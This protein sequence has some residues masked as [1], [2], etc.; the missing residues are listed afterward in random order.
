ML[1][2][3]ELILVS[4][5]ALHLLPL[6]AALL[7]D[8]TPL[9]DQYPLVYLSNAALAQTLLKRREAGDRPTERL[10]MGPPGVDLQCAEVETDELAEDWGLKGA[11]DPETRQPYAR[12]RM[13]VQ[14]L[15]EQARCLERAHLATHSEFD[16]KDYLRSNIHF[17]GERLTLAHLISDADFDFKGMRLFYLSSCESGLSALDRTD[18]LQGLVWSLIYAG[19]EAVMASKFYDHWQPGTSL[20][21]AYQAALRELR[22]DPNFENPYYWAP[23]VLFGNGF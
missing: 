17:Y 18:E 1:V 20:M 13:R 4:N 16:F 21:Q 19:A 6:H 15:R 2:P 3:T 5:G 8:G 22:A 10:V 7:K 14:V 9:I 23:F 11:R 12:E